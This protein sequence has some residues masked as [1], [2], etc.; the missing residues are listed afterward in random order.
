[1][2]ESVPLVPTY[3]RS[4]LTRGDG[5]SPNGRT[6]FPST[7]GTICTMISSSR[8]NAGTSRATSAPK[9]LT[10]RPRR[11][12]R[13]AP[14]QSPGPRPPPPYGRTRAVPDDVSRPQPVLT[15]A[16]VDS[17]DGSPPSSA[18]ATSRQP[19]PA[20]TTPVERATSSA[21]WLEESYSA[22]PIQ[23]MSCP[24][25]AMNP[26]RDIAPYKKT[27]LFQTV[28]EANNHR[29]RGAVGAAGYSRSRR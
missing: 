3:V 6:P 28:S 7:I 10:A 17:G 4:C 24:G 27:M 11:I 21:S 16:S 9:M 26:S 29:S 8:P 5:A 19:R 13:P 22:P 15:S 23:D 14:A 18:P 25:P 1:M 2:S 12:P 20:S